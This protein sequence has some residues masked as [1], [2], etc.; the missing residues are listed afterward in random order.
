MLEAWACR[1]SLYR[2]M[3]RVCWLALYSETGM[4]AFLLNTRFQ[5]TKRRFMLRF[6][7]DRTNFS[8][9]KIAPVSWFKGQIVDFECGLVRNPKPGS[10]VSKC[11]RRKVWISLT[12]WTHLCASEPNNEQ[13]LM[14]TDLREVSWSWR[15]D[16]IPLSDEI[17][18]LWPNNALVCV[19]QNTNIAE[20]CFLWW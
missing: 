14:K 17:I 18:T 8:V 2:A 19:S 1:S 5:K 3:G 11:E 16:P 7:Q 12:F 6:A 20:N 15:C 9:Q 10:D 13:K 4:M